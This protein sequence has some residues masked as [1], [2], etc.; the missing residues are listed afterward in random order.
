M[1]QIKWIGFLGAVYTNTFR[2]GAV[3]S[4]A[5]CVAHS[6]TPLALIM[7]TACRK[8]SR[9]SKN[10]CATYAPL[11][12]R[13]KL[14]LISLSKTTIF[15]SVPK[16]YSMFKLMILQLCNFVLYFTIY[17]HY[18]KWKC[19]DPQTSSSSETRS[20]IHNHATSLVRCATFTKL[21]WFVLSTLCA[22]PPSDH[23]L[24][25]CHASVVLKLVIAAYR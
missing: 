5:T 14:T 22:R 10:N 13:N 25:R 16:I 19:Q 3:I 15:T 7:A 21:M 18:K 23:I 9:Y 11:R 8:W 4:S 24:P 1:Y 17:G 6:L 2:P 20:M 12:R